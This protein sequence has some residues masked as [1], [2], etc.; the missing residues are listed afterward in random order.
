MWARPDKVWAAQVAVGADEGVSQHPLE[1]G[2][3]AAHGLADEG[4]AEELI[5]WR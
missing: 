3:S 5:T 1:L 2:S 4:D